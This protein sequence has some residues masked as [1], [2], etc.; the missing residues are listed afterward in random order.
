MSAKFLVSFVFVLS[1]VFGV[2]AQSK[3]SRDRSYVMVPSAEIT[4]AIVAQ[5]GAPVRIE[6]PKLFMNMQTHDF[7]ISYNV[8]NVGTKAIS[9]VTPVMWTSY[10]TGGTLNPHPATG[11]LEP[12]AIIKTSA[13]EQVTELT[14]ELRNELGWKGRM[15]GLLIVMIERVTFADGTTYLDVDASNA[16][17]HYFEVL[18]DKLERLQNLEKSATLMPRKRKS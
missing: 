3:T 4:L 10:G 1:A 2:D 18:S 11:V 15:K 7:E 8:R 9:S 6:D 12:G 14:A 5:P 16:L 13:P 17:L